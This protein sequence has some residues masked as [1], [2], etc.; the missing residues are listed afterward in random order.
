MVIKLQ[1]QH[2]EFPQRIPTTVVNSAREWLNDKIIIHLRVN[3]EHMFPKVMDD[4]ILMLQ[5]DE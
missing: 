3:L 1:K 5:T 4:R 2:S